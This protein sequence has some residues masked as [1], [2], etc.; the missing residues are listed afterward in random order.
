L[1]AA[2][3]LSRIAERTL[4]RVLGS[5]NKARRLALSLFFRAALGIER[6][7]HFDTLDDPGFAI[8]TGG[9]KVMSRSRLGGLVRAVKTVGVKKFARATEE[10]R[11]LRNQVVTLSLDEHVIARF[12]RKFKIPKGFHT[13]RNKKMRAEKLFYLYWPAA[14]RFLGLVVARGNEKL[15]DH[16]IDFIRA[17]RRRVH[18]RQ[19]RL[20]LDASA[21]ATHEGLRRL[22]RFHKTVFLIRAP[23]RP[24]YINAWKQLPRESFTQLEEPGRFE[25]AKAKEIGIAETTTSIAG[26]ARPLRTIVA[27]E[28]AMKGKDRWHALFVLHDDTTPPLDLLHE[29]RT[30]QHHEQGYRIGVHDLWIDASPSGYPKSG[31]PDRPGF[32]RGPLTLCAWIAALAWD[33]LRALGNALPARFHLAHPRTLRRWVLMRDADVILTPSHLLI[34]LTFTKRRSWLRPLLQRFNEANVALPW[35]GGRHVVMGFAARAQPLSNARPVLP[36]AAEVG[37]GSANGCGGVWC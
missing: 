30:R 22:N 33:A 3:V 14:R 35:L 34:V 16:A 12:T 7:F 1:P 17:L 25:G 2:L 4:K 10:L 13:I 9:K 8:L 20:I 18:L 19:L 36:E 31:R 23:R 5:T 15:V 21:S 32:R 11:A 37:Y 24:A 28:R 27:R 29:F 26:I 6:I